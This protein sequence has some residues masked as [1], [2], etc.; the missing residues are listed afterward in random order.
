MA[1]LRVAGTRP[2]DLEISFAMKERDSEQLPHSRTALAYRAKHNPNTG[3][4]SLSWHEQ[5]GRDR[6][7]VRDPYGGCDNEINAK[8]RRRSA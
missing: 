7:R 1:G 8:P 2:A 5:G 4:P 6:A 3:T